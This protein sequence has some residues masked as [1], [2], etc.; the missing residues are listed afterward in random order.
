MDAVTYPDERVRE[1]LSERLVPF[2]PQIDEH[3]D[4]ARR[5][6]V[7]W[8]PGLVWLGPDGTACHTNVGYFAPEEW[9]AESLFAA[10]QSA[11]GQADWES[12]RDHFLEVAEQW[13]RTH[14][15]PAGLYWAGVASKKVTGEPDE[16]VRLWNGLSAQH[17]ESAWAMK[18]SFLGDE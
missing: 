3:E 12:A 17:P 7:T 10:G 18:V 4:L 6:G 11:A 15:A 1:F 14:A 5:Y 16:L 2:K 8:T 9:V 13:P